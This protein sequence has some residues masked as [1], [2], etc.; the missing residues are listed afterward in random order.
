MLTITAQNVNTAVAQALPYLIKEGEREESRNG[1]VLVAP[2]PVC[3]VYMQ[4][5]ER[6]LFSPIRDANPFFHLMES[7]WM[8]AGRN[9]VTF[10][11]FFNKRFSEYS[12][13]GY[14]VHGAYGYRW[15]VLF[16]MDQLAH[17]ADELT[18]KPTSRRAVLQMWNALGDLTPVQVKAYESNEDILVGGIASKDVPCNTHAYFDVRH[19]KLNMT[20][21]CR[22]N[23]VVWGAYGAN[24]V[25]FSMLLEYMAAMIGVQV[26][27]YRQF[28]NN[29]HMYT[30]LYGYGI[31]KLE[32]MAKEAGSTNY[33]NENI[34]GGA[35]HVTPYPLVSTDIKSWNTDLRN[36]MR[37]PKGATTYGDDF[38]NKVAVPMFRA[39]DERKA[40]GGNGLKFIDQIA[41]DDWRLACTQWACRREKGN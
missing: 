20:V 35:V 26:G 25:H 16:G 5:L 21:L 40:K 41:A 24:A 19:G 10:P 33:Y 6:V 2:E 12:D 1:T 11:A 23:D 32:A 7:L 36:F 9:D 4:P 22:S 27:I 30:E 13:D 8:L 15:R 34:D 17:L 28:S 31:D 29:F 18:N 37:N 39:W 14:I 38:F 3:T